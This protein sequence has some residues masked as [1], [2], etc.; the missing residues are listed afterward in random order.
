[1]KISNYP[2]TVAREGEGLVEQTQTLDILL[3]SIAE[4]ART[5][6][7]SL[8]FLVARMHAILNEEFEEK[9]VELIRAMALNKVPSRL[10]Y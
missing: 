6:G 5:E 2:Y 3:L 1:M 7:A 4:G 9:Q 8:A 10:R